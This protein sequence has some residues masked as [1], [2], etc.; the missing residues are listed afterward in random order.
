MK[1]T[2]AQIEERY[3]KQLNYEQTINH[4]IT[5]VAAA[6][7]VFDKTNIIHTVRGLIHLLPTE[8]RELALARMNAKGLTIH[9]TTNEEAE[10]W[11]ALWD[12]CLDHLKDANLIF[13]EGKGPAETGE[14]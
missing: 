13:K 11:L 10:E 6:V 3:H 1:E 9:S 5:Q 7:S 8:R 14:L 12:Y 2:K 4:Q